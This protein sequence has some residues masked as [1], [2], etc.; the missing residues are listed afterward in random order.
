MNPATPGLILHVDDEHAVRE[1]L[2]MLLGSDGYNVLSAAS[3]LEALQLTARGNRPDVLIVDFNI[4]H[5][6]NGTELVRQYQRSVGYAPPIIMLTADPVSADPP[7]M[8]NAPIWMARKPLDPRLLLAALPS[9][10]QWSRATRE[11]LDGSAR[12]V[13]PG[14]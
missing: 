9:L 12:V 13:P 14:R 1:S 11:L 2:S 3:G 10:V 6:M 4:D 5:E 7:R 8:T